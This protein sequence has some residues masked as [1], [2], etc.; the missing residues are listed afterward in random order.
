MRLQWIVTLLFIIFCS[1]I[2][3]ALAEINDEP[4]CFYRTRF[5]NN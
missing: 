3:T 5:Q 2:S 1:L 4:L